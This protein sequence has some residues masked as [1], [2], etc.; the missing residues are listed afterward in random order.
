[1][2]AAF[3]DPHSLSTPYGRI[4]CG[5]IMNGKC[6]IRTERFSGCYQGWQELR[7][8]QKFASLTVT[9]EDA[10]RHPSGWRFFVGIDSFGWNRVSKVQKYDCGNAGQQH[11]APQHGK[12]Q[13]FCPEAAGP[14]QLVLLLDQGENA[15]G[16]VVLAQGGLP[17]GAGN[18]QKAKKNCYR[19]LPGSQR[20]V[21]SRA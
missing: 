19:I 12:Q 1:M 20:M 7:N 16:G 17:R 21:I 4:D 15:V 10:N 3:E 18:V 9:C 13:G 5:T 2:N 14:E 11:R 8:Y 6:L